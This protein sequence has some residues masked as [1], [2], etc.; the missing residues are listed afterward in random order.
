[1]LGIVLSH[2]IHRS[3]SRDA[4]QDC[5]TSKCSPSTATSVGTGNLDALG[6]CTRPGLAE[7]GRRSPAIKG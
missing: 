4:I 5:E 7:D 3:V 6:L 2:V 1:M